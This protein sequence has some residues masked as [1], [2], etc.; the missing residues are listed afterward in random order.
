MQILSVSLPHSSG[1]G[2][3]E[4]TKVRAGE[5]CVFRH[6]KSMQLQMLRIP[7]DQGASLPEPV[8]LV[9]DCPHA[10]ARLRFK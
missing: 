4:G 5:L 3:R 7:T 10:A 8:P 2:R 6:V 9:C 1:G